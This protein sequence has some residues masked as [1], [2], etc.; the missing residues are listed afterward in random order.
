VVKGYESLFTRHK[1]QL[2]GS[3]F[4]VFHAIPTSSGPDYDEPYRQLAR[5]TW[6]GFESWRF[7]QPRFV[8]RYKS[9]VPKLKNYLDYTFVRLVDLEQSERGTY[10]KYSSDGNMV[11]FN[12]GLQNPHQSDLL[13]TF[14]KAKLNPSKPG[15][16]WIYQGCYAPNDDGYRKFFPQEYHDIALYSKDSKDF[17]FDTSYQLQKD[18]FDHLVDRA[19]DRAG[20]PNASDE[21]IKNYLRGTIESLVPKIK[22]NYKVAIPVFYVKEKRMQLLLPFPSA[23]SKN[24][25]SSFLVERDDSTK[26]YILKTIF[27]LDQAYFSARLITRP[28]QEWLN[29]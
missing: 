21:G 22:R 17:V 23:S 24:E 20:L 13:A 27:D 4:A 10:F 1:N 6:D 12:T 18:T 5:N 7:Q 29:P 11:C 19:R 15:C 25:F 16:D 9:D 28:D 14:K 3:A 8:T 26:T 2:V